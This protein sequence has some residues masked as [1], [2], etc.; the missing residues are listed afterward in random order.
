MQTTTINRILVNPEALEF[1]GERFIAIKNNVK[2][3]RKMTPKE[4]KSYEIAIKYIRGMFHLQ[5]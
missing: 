3:F 1:S 2:V 5:V 4:I